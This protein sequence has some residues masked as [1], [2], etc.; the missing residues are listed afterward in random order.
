MTLAD[1]E[2]STWAAAVVVCGRIASDMNTPIATLAG[3]R[4]N[5]EQRL[6]ALGSS[7]PSEAPRG[8]HPSTS[9]SAYGFRRE[10]P[11]HV[12]QRAARRQLWLAGC[13]A[14]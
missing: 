3:E 8:F 12:N 13:R 4:K 14:L 6:S 9:L 7:Q 5:D 11:A 2:M 1:G 10:P